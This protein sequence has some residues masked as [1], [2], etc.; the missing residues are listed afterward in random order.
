MTKSALQIARAAYQ[1]KLPKALKGHV[2]AVAGEATQSVADQEAIQKLFPNTYGMPLIKFETSAEA[3]S[4]PVMNVGV[5]LSG[6]Q[7]PG[8]HNVIS[9]LFDGIKKL[10]PENI[11]APPFPIYRAF[12]DHSPPNAAIPSSHAPRIPTFSACRVAASNRTRDRT[13]VSPL[14]QTNAC[15]V[16]CSPRGTPHRPP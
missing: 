3:V 8:G 1:P 5:I 16:R 11:E 12:R 2:K 9:G 10:N 14:V 15:S 13:N 6:G 7:A 4:F